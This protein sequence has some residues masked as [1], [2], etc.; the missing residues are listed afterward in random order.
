MFF[1]AHSVWLIMRRVDMI[2][3]VHMVDVNDPEALEEFRE[4]LRFR[5]DRANW[6]EISR[7]MDIQ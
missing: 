2:A 3:Q 5:Y 1:V 6:N 4:N 7:S